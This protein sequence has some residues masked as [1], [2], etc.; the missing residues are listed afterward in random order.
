MSTT[1][2]EAVR[3]WFEPLKKYIPFPF[4]GKIDQVL[5]HEN[6]RK[7]RKE[8]GDKVFDEG[9]AALRRIATGETLGKP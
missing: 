5:T 3:V 7:W 2:L 8:T 1:D 9:M 6:I 4:R